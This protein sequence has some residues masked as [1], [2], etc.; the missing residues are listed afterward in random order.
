MRGDKGFIIRLSAKE[1]EEFHLLG[2]AAASAQDTPW[3]HGKEIKE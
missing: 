3:L 2:E 1:V